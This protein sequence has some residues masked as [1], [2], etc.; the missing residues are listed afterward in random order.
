MTMT[1]I[2]IIDYFFNAPKRLGDYEHSIQ[3]E[4]SIESTRASTMRCDGSVD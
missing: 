3:I 2:S 1:N 4:P